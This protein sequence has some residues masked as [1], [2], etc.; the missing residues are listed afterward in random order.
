VELSS[1]NLSKSINDL[2]NALGEMRKLHP[3]Y[4][5]LVAEELATALERSG[6]K[7]KA[8]QVLHDTEQ[9]LDSLGSGY[10]VD[11]WNLDPRLHLARLSRERGDSAAAER[12]ENDLRAQLAMADPDDALAAALHNPKSRRVFTF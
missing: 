12:I 7:D 8:F 1:G 9:Y 3:G 10:F 4:I 11:V 5:P 6:E 2:Q